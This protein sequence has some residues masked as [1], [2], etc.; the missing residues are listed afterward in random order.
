MLF[1]KRTKKKPKIKQQEEEE[2]IIENLRGFM[3]ERCETSHTWKT[4]KKKNPYLYKIIT[5][6]LC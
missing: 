4:L 3:K 1:F 2:D 6:D 5:D